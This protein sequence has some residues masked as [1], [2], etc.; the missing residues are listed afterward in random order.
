MEKGCKWIKQ[1]ADDKVVQ[2]MDSAAYFV[3]QVVQLP[4]DP[5]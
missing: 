2:L 4:Q 5:L 3:V 1:A